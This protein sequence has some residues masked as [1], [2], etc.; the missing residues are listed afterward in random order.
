[1]HGHAVSNSTIP[2][3]L[4]K[5]RLAR[6][7]PFRGFGGRAREWLCDTHARAWRIRAH[8]AVSVSVGLP[9]P[10]RGT[11]SSSQQCNSQQQQPACL[12]SPSIPLYTRSA[13]NYSSLQRKRII[14][15]SQFLVHFAAFYCFCLKRSKKEFIR[16]AASAIYLN[17][18]IALSQKCQLHI[19]F[20][21]FQNNHHYC[22]MA[23]P[24][25]LSMHED[26]ALDHD[27]ST[28]SS[29]SNYND[30]YDRD[31]SSSSYH[32]DTTHYY[33]NY[34]ITTS[35]TIRVTPRDDYLVSWG[36]LW[37]LFVMASIVAA[38]QS[39]QEQLIL[40]ERKRGEEVE[41]TPAGTM[42]MM[43]TDGEGV[44]T[45]DVTRFMVCKV[46]ESCEYRS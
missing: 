17:V 23:S 26:Y 42:M 27:P 30:E 15:H 7:S 3:S 24:L 1:M 43:T 25:I 2:K 35:V 19:S 13:D 29:S 34:S 38:V 4:S 20:V 44:S 12:L 11:A 8:A 39:R 33:S 10:R 40:A 28:L 32:H 21:L 45:A 18:S 22:I 9:P 14:A 36:I 5:A 41:T 16:A 46:R 37:G 31:L 6:L